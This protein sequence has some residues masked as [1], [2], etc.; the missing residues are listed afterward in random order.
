[1]LF[2][3]GRSYDH[4]LVS[5]AD[6]SLGFRACYRRGSEGETSQYGHHF[7]MYG[8]GLR[9]RLCAWVREGKFGKGSQPGFTAVDDVRNCRGTRMLVAEYFAPEMKCHSIEEV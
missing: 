3:A 2:V 8:L 9:P 5:D 4:D 7:G 1:M 6:L